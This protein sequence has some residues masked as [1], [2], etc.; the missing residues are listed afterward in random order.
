MAIDDLATHVE[1]FLDQCVRENLAAPHPA[2][3]L[4]FDKYGLSVSVPRSFVKAA[5][6]AADAAAS[7]IPPDAAVA[8]PVEDGPKKLAKKSTQSTLDA[9]T[10]PAAPPPPPPRSEA[11]AA[12]ASQ[13]SQQRK[14]R[15]H[16]HSREGRNPV[17]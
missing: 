2:D 4:R 10:A 8:K 11:E 14:R 3:V 9:E 5:E 16:H 17:A 13:D 12:P 7:A 15:R 6:S 1:K